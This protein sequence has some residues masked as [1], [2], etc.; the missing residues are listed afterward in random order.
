MV[1]SRAGTRASLQPGL[2]PLYPFR[3]RS[4]SGLLQR[5]R[6]VAKA[7]HERIAPGRKMRTD[8]TVVESNVHYP[9]DSSLLADGIRVLSRAL[10]GISQEC[11]AGSV[12][13]VD[14]ARATK[15]R[16]L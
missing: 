8:T 12:Q 1:V 5:V 4:D 11:A 16:V 3:P 2:P 13:I 15:H 10:K 9:T 6:V 14:H 7:R